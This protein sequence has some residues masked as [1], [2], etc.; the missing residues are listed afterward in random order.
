MDKFLKWFSLGILAAVVL[1]FVGSLIAAFIAATGFK[2]AIQDSVKDFDTCAAVY[3]KIL[4]S[5][6]EQCVTP[7]GERFIRDIG[8]SLDPAVSNLIT[9]TSP[10]PGQVIAS[11]VAIEG[12][13]RGYWYFEASFPV[14]ITDEYGNLMA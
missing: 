6:P 12:Q 14:K 2:N 7:D 4:E 8:N 3:G 9:L 11:P 5:Y 10:T 13:A 1:V